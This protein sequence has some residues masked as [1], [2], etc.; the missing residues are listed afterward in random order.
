MELKREERRPCP[1]FGQVYPQ[2]SHCC[3]GGRGRESASTACDGTQGGVAGGSGARDARAPSARVGR[4]RGGR[5][6]AAGSV[7]EEAGT[8]EPG[9]AGPVESHKGT[10]R[11]LCYHSDT[12]RPTPRSRGVD[13]AGR[14]DSR[15]AGG[16][17]IQPGGPP[18]DAGPARPCRLRAV[19]ARVPVHSGRGPSRHLCL[20][21]HCPASAE[22]PRH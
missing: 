19:W 11:G 16:A 15:V 22:L 10:P 14:S 13:R 2:D 1:P 18:R 12:R 21:R 3:R 17:G 4:G 8:G 6:G 9:L 20:V 5:A 7:R